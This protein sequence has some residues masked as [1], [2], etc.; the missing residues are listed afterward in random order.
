MSLLIKNGVIV[1]A[2][3]EYEADVFVEDGKISAIGE[4]LRGE[5]DEIVDAEGMYLLPGGVDQHVHYSFEY[6]GNRSRGFETTDAAVIGGTTTVVEFVNQE[7][8]KGLIESLEDYNEKKVKDKAMA[9]YSFHAV[10]TDPSDDI[11]EEIRELPEAGY[12]QI[13]LFMA[14]KGQFFHSDDQT[15]AKAMK[16]AGEVGVTTFVHA[17]NADMI[18]ILEKELV[19]EGKMG[20]YSHA[21]S[22]PPLVETEATERAIRIAEFAD[23]P[24]YIAHVTNKD[25]VDAIRRAQERGLSVY[26]ETCTHYLLLDKENLNKEDFEG[27]K[28]VLAPPL[29]EQDD[30]DYLWKSVQNN[31]LN[32][33]S[34][35]HCA[36]NFEDEKH[37]GINDWRDIPN[38][39]PGVQNRLGILWTIGVETGKISPSKLVDLFAT[40][41]AKVAGLGDR[42]GKIAIGYDAD[43]VIYNPEVKETISYKTNA[44]GVDYS[45]YEGME[46]IGRA[47]TVFLRGQKVVEDGEYVGKGEGQGE[48]IPGKA[49]GLAY[50]HFEKSKNKNF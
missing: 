35:D 12:S 10:I 28:Y 5:A 36:Y 26:G 22:R 48:F 20:P 2:Q 21:L 8:G 43:M 47:E 9:D 27:A 14:Y 46:Q 31:W 13:K 38:G 19:E 44:E 7:R 11:Y 6:K 18:D 37:I 3:D 15:L 32:A 49:Y 1:S 24:L 23:A 25:S 16:V 17:E 40:T 39:A 50:D 41:P 29:R 45:P 30:I 34:T 33:I 4:N 42:K